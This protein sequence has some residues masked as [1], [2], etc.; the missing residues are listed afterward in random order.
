MRAL[1]SLVASAIVALALCSTDGA[2][3][4][5]RWEIPGGNWQSLSDES[6]AIDFGV[7]GAIQIAGFEPTSNITQSLTWE[8][9]VCL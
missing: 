4:I 5:T 8:C 2:A 3:Q 1:G 6:T 9:G 7:S